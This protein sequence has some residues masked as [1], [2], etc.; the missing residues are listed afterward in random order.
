MLCEAKQA[1][2]APLS[3]DIRAYSDVLPQMFFPILRVA[4]LKREPST[5]SPF[6][7][8]FASSR[9]HPVW[10]PCGF[11]MSSFIMSI[12]KDNEYSL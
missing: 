1:A 8:V 12:D 4:P 5:Y 11:I 6:P 3:E 10:T 2:S 9:V 7:E